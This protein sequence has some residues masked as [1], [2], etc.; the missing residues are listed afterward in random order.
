MR[1]SAV[2]TLTKNTNTSLYF[3]NFTFIES[4][5]KG[6]LTAQQANTYIEAHRFKYSVYIVLPD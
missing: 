4:L 3:N 6:K 2:Y 5:I 1:N